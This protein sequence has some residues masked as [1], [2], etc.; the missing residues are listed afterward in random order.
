MNLAQPVTE[1]NEKLIRME[2][3]A[4]RIHPY[5]QRDLVP[6]RLKEL[7]A[8]FDLDAIGI[9]HAVEY[10]IDGYPGPW[11]VDGQHRL[12]LLK[13][14][15]LG[16]WPV[17]VRIHT[18]AKDHAASAALFLKLNNR[19]LVSSF[20]K[21]VNARTAEYESAVGVN[22]IVSEH[23]YTVGKT[24]RDA[25]LSCVS[26][27]MKLYDLDTGATL[28]ATLE[29]IIAAWGRVA[30]ACEGKLIEGIGQV[31]KTYNG[32]IDRPVLAKKLA[33]YPGGPSGLLGD[34]KGIREYRRGSLSRCLAEKIIDLYNAGRRVG[35]LDPL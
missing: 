9:L 32:S 26:T 2:A 23:G 3:Q 17:I 16:E 20:A 18:D 27:L 4:L 6:A 12:H 30:S 21:F 22:R 31:Y 34:A 7:E 35:R 24:T 1:E 25:E 8:D 14:M 33:K 28:A 10:Q 11:C 15:G 5:A 29:T 19:L 13:N